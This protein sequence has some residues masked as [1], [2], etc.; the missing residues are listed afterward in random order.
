[1]RLKPARIDPPRRTKA[2]LPLIPPG[3]I[4]FKSP[5]TAHAV[6]LFLGRRRRG[7]RVGVAGGETLH[8]SWL[9]HRRPKA[10]SQSQPQNGLLPEAWLSL[11]C[12]AASLPQRQCAATGLTGPSHCSRSRGAFRKTRNRSCESLIVLKSVCFESQATYSVAPS[13]T[14]VLL[15]T[16]LERRHRSSRTPNETLT[17]QIWLFNLANRISP[18]PLNSFWCLCGA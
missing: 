8:C 13:V 1:M 17:R 15:L 16:H 5:Y 11:S 7:R 18:D 2:R 4:D 10:S 3:V 14:T 9:P 12:W 6:L